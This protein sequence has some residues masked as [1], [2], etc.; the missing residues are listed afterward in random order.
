M[1]G[2][3]P[4]RDA[5]RVRRNKPDVPT[6][7]GAA[8]PTDP[9]AED[10][11]WHVVAK[12]L[13]RSIKH[14]GQSKF[15]QQTDWEYARLTMDQLSKMLDSAGDKPLRATQLTEI[16]S[17]LGQLMFTEPER[18]RARIELQH[19][20]EAGDND[21]DATVTDINAARGGAYG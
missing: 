12:R 13:Y 11:K 8:M 4:K 2:P 7:I 14:S 17:M 9:P 3:M 5:D 15:W 1:P 20:S 18:R 6:R 16:N 10:R 21:T 19:A